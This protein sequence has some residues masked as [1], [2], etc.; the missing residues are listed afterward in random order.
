M[1]RSECRGFIRRRSVVF[2]GVDSTVA[3]VS[4]RGVGDALFS[5][6]RTTVKLGVRWACRESLL[7]QFVRKLWRWIGDAPV[8]GAATTH[9]HGTTRGPLSSSVHDIAPSNRSPGSLS[10]ARATPQRQIAFS[11]P[12]APPRPHATPYSSTESLPS[13]A[14]SSLLFVMPK[15]PGRRRFRRAPSEPFRP[16]R[17]L[18]HI[19]LLQSIFYLLAGLLILFSA[20]VAGSPFNLDLIFSWSSVRTDDV[21]GWTLLVV[22]VLV[23]LFM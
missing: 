16:L 20:V 6:L 5:N 2:V 17:T 3:A 13:P 22:W 9:F 14:T 12:R 19:A 11:P 7:F 15:P 23:A 18:L 4:V 21:V 8:G 10:G 1:F